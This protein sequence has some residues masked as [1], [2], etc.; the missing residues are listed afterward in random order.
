MSQFLFEQQ[1]L[2]FLRTDLV[3][4]ILVTIFKGLTIFFFALKHSTDEEPDITQK[5][6][7]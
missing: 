6:R 2:N 7:T 5:E 4:C 3:H 1:H